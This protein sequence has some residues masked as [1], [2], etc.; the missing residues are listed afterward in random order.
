MKWLIAV[1]AGFLVATGAWADEAVAPDVMVRNV[2]DD[3]LA[4]VRKDKDIQNGDPRKVVDLVETKVLPHFDFERMTSLAVGKDWRRASPAQRATLID[5]FR[6][7]L[8]RTYSKALTEYRNQTMTIKLQQMQPDRTEARVRA[9][10]N[11]PGGKSILIDY[12]LEARDQAWKVFDISVDGISLVTN[13]RSNFAQEVSANGIDG[14][15]SSLRN[16]N[17]SDGASGSAKR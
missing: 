10:V 2:T 3:V 4:I 12:D 13:Y 7:L 9:K 8:V 17:Q 15:I 14:L 1:L 5:E 6:T 11:Q 16:K